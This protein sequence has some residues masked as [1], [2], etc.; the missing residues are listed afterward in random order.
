VDAAANVRGGPR[1]RK[2]WRENSR[3]AEPTLARKKREASIAAWLEG[4]KLGER[5]K[6]LF[7]F[8]KNAITCVRGKERG[9]LKGSRLILRERQKP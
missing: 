6:I 2:G 8:R 9:I 3:Q 1:A 7:F 4:G 5:L